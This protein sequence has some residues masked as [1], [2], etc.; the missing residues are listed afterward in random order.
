MFQVYTDG[1]TPYDGMDNPAVV[2]MVFGGYRAPMPNGCPLE[3]YELLLRCWDKDPAKRPSF[4]DL[5]R[6]FGFLATG[7]TI[8][9]DNAQKS[10]SIR[11]NITVAD[12]EEI[13]EIDEL[14]VHP[15]SAGTID[16]GDNAGGYDAQYEVPVRNA[17]P[18][19][20]AVVYETP[21]AQAQ[22]VAA[23]MSNQ[24]VASKVRPY[25][26]RGPSSAVTN[27]DNDSLELVGA[28]TSSGAGP[29]RAVAHYDNEIEALVHSTSAGVS[30]IPPEYVHSS[31]TE[32]P[33][34]TTVVG[35]RPAW[36]Q[37]IQN[38]ET[39]AATSG[40]VMNRTLAASGTTTLRR[41][42]ASTHQAQGTPPSPTWLSWILRAADTEPS[43]HLN[44]VN[45]LSGTTAGQNAH[46]Q[47]LEPSAG[48]DQR[49]PHR[50][51]I[52]RTNCGGVTVP[53]DTRESGSSAVVYQTRP[54]GTRVGPPSVPM[55]EVRHAADAATS[56]AT[57]G[58]TAGLRD[59]IS[60]VSVQSVTDS[61]QTGAA[62]SGNNDDD[63]D[64][65]VS[66]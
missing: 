59:N 58:L 39:G 47:V 51:I 12:C 33:G 38:N 34:V 26:D 29:S 60:L 64:S 55:Y 62:G 3:V 48:S 17:A 5:A 54:I 50:N 21:E 41:D 13:I 1:T 65:D 61:E 45:Q 56:G 25:T 32:H 9:L 16:N 22:H 4:A 66:L 46:A 35:E 2:S 40:I 36:L 49:L 31:T 8:A 30:S 52:Y 43:K 24:S 6:D 57:T 42:V 18:Q 28:A 44:K 15:D 14:D 53:S 37:W 11:S 27:Y 20:N 19:S 23:T 10:A 63:N 7:G